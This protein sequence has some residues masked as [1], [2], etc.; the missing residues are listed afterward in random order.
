MVGCL[1]ADASSSAGVV[2]GVDRA[3]ECFA[4]NH[5]VRRIHKPTLA[6]GRAGDDN[7]Q[8]NLPARAHLLT[9]IAYS[10][11]KGLLGGILSGEGG[12]GTDF[13]SNEFEEK[14]FLVSSVENLLG[15][16]IFSGSALTSLWSEFVNI[17]SVTILVQRDKSNWPRC[18][19]WHGWLPALAYPGSRSTLG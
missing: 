16:A 5:Q 9:S 8:Q 17:L 11:D 1:R 19:L 18:L 12:G 14:V 3:A 15:M 13:F 4:R 10:R 6:H 7:V 2:C